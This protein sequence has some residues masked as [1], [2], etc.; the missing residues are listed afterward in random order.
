MPTKLYGAPVVKSVPQVRCAQR[1][2]TARADDEALDCCTRIGERAR[3]RS[4]TAHLSSSPYWALKAQA[5][6]ATKGTNDSSNPSQTSA[7][8]GHERLEVQAGKH[9]RQ[10]QQRLV[11][12]AQGK[13]EARVAGYYC[14][15]N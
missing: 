1:V 13:L 5:Q 6:T 12:A 15:G 8:A 4:C 14:T 9:A 3:P 2:A 11:K 10:C 7:A